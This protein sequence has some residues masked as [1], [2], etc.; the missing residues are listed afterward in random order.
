[1][2]Y[3]LDTK[4]EVFSLAATSMA[5][6]AEEIQSIVRREGVVSVDPP[7]IVFVEGVYEGILLAVVEVPADESKQRWR[8]H[9]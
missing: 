5:T 3:G 7:T 1:M 4:I 2:S 9:G 8:A 6:I